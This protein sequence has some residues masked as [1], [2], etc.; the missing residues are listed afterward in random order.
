[1]APRLQSGTLVPAELYSLQI[2]CGA[3]REAAYQATSAGGGSGGGGDDDG[4]GDKEKG[5]GKKL[6]EGMFSG[7]KPSTSLNADLKTTFSEKW[8][9]TVGGP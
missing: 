4:G 7:W 8:V 1:M 9:N 2:C 3:A 5:L 6:V